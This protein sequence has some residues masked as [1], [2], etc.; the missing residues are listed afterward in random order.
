[1]IPST[2]ETRPPF[3]STFGAGQML[4]AIAVETDQWKAMWL[5]GVAEVEERLTGTDD[6]TAELAAELGAL[7]ERVW[8]LIGHIEA[9]DARRPR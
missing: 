2:P 8:A 5:P 1:M 9:A 7:R 6:L 4:R 3:T